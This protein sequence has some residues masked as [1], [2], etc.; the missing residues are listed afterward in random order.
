[1][2]RDSSS[3]PPRRQF[4]RTLALAC[5]WGVLAAAARADGT[6]EYAIKAAYLYNF[7]KFVEW[8]ADRFADA[9]SPI[10]IGIVGKNV[11]GGELEEAVR[12]RKVNGRDVVV[13]E[14]SSEKELRT[15]HLLFVAVGDE[16]SFKPAAATGM[17]TVGE[18]PEFT[19]R[20]GM[21]TF[22]PQGDKIRFTINLDAAERAGLKLSAQ[23]LKLASA[24]QR[25][26]L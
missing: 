14:V 10:V 19:E 17:L 25:K 1:M 4:C 21:V 5:G 26:P 2:P 18:S 24:V 13:V 20:G 15:A 7:A 3:S 9:K 11:F 22:V 8:P 12:G 16:K 6:K 23:L